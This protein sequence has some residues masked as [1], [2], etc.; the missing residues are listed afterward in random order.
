MRHGFIS[1]GGKARRFQSQGSKPQIQGTQQA[2]VAKP[3]IA[4]IPLIKRRL[5]LLN[6]E[7]RTPNPEPITSHSLR[8]LPS[9]RRP[10]SRLNWSVADLVIPVISIANSRA[11]AA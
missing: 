10:S 6:L 1:S 3:Q 5:G 4:Q 2:T 8:R 11:A 9:Y 7:L